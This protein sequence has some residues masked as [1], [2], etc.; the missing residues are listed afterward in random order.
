MKKIKNITV[1]TDFSVTARNAYRYANAL[2]NELNAVL[3]IV[4]VKNDLMATSGVMPKSPLEDDKKLISD[5]EALVAEE[6]SATNNFKV[7]RDVKIN[8]YLGN[9]VV[10]LT[11]LSKREDT[12]LI[13]IGTTGLSDVL[14]KIF[15][16]T[17]VKVSNSAV[18]PVILVPRDAKWQAIKHIMFASNYESMTSKYV[19]NISDFAV[20]LRADV[21]FVNVK[22]FDPVFE[23]KQEEINWDELIVKD[24]NLSFEKHTVY[25]ND[26]IEQL[27]NY[28]EEKGINLMAFVSEHRNFW[29]KLIHKSV[30]ENMALSTITPI[31]VLHLDDE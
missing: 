5:I 17:S 20:A 29:E 15:G 30:T 2:A 4:H 6:N 16:S 27:K 10:V 14:T 11:E 18:C 31:M 21:H 22:N 1:A 8:I 9:P 12:D 26:T 23:K 28:S 24:P 19:Q 3:T 13:I 7:N 25:G